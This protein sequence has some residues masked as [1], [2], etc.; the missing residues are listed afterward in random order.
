MASD[1]IHGHMFIVLRSLLSVVRMSPIGVAPNAVLVGV[2]LLLAGIGSAA[3]HPQ[4][5]AAAGMLS[6]ERRAFGISV[7][8]FDG[9]V[10]F[11]I[12]PLA[13]LGVIHLWGLERRCHIAAHR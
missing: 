2:L 7:F 12:G 1:R 6:G 13:I 3:F 8:T 4:A 10:G 5:V 11:A 9:S